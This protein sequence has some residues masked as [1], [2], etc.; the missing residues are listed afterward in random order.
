MSASRHP[1]SQGYDQAARV[2]KEALASGRSLREVVLERGLMSADALDRAL[3]P[4]TMTGPACAGL[5]G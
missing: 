2:A 1:N 3:D 4:A 5:S